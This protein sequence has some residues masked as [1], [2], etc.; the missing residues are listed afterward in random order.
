MKIRSRTCI[1]FLLFFFVLLPGCAATSEGTASR[2][3]EADSLSAAA[4][5]LFVDGA[6]A[7]AKGDYESAV[8]KYREVLL[9]QSRN[10]AVHFALSRV[11]LV[12]S[13]QDS[14][15]YYS[16]RA[17]Y[18][19]PGNRFYRKLLAGICFEMKDY[20]AAADQF[21][22]LVA[23]EPSDIR[24]L[25]YL[26][27]SYLAA[28]M[29]EQAL[30]AFSRILSVDP[31]DENALTQS[32]WLQFKL[33]RYTSAIATLEKLMTQGGENE[34]L[35]L[36][37]GEL[38][39]RTGQPKKA[40]DTFNRVIV[41]DASYLPAW[42][43]V[44][45]VRADQGD[46]EVFLGD[47][48]RFYAGEDIAYE[49]KVEA[50]RLFMLKARNDETYGALAEVMTGEFVKAFPGKADAY[51]V[52]GMSRL[53]RKEY[54][55]AIEDFRKA[56]AI[57]PRNESARVELVSA[58]MTQ[59]DYRQALESVRAAGKHLR[60]SSL[61]LTVLEG[62]A[63]FRSERS[64]EAIQVLDRAASFDRDDNPEWQ[65]IQA[66]LTQAMAFDKLQ[67]ADKSMAAYEAVLELDS[68]NAL[69]Q[70]NLAYLFA[71]RGLHLQRAFELSSK[72]VEADPENPVFL[73]TLGWIYF[74][75]GDYRKARDILR[76]A[77]SGKP[78]EP[79]I[80]E[81]LAEVYR[82]LGDSAKAGR[83]MENARKIR[84]EGA[85]EKA[86]ETQK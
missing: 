51:V 27:H 28:G 48:R 7:A 57:D 12:Q 32:L 9:S 81:H 26:A 69:A 10:A 35:L 24:T 59:G 78:E 47:L 25:F 75:M 33:K 50:T 68:E 2:K 61:R 14:A 74:R 39:L 38:Y 53:Y 55:P 64:R 45:E 5:R 3:V 22:Q 34:K 71:E 66:R 4:D 60:E 11:F 20:R 8:S 46:R 37:L 31:A 72:A 23:G 82:V 85:L 30:N 43:A 56:V 83:F 6:F 58:W 65:F 36:T 73:D 17:V 42:I 40:L 63:L 13:K 84:R 15:R 21:E 80:H 1:S 70:N 16:E 52:R 67:E 49:G 44:L 77:L 62:Y 29:N 76:K 18:Y 54:G 86:V 79:E 19:N 41:A